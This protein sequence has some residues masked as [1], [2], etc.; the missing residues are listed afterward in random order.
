MRLKSILIFATTFGC[1]TLPV[2]AQDSGANN[3]AKRK[4]ATVAKP[5][6]EKER[7]KQQEKLR[8]ELETPYKKWLNE[9]VVYIITDEE[10][11]AFKTLQTDEEREQFI[12]QFWLRRDPTSGHRRKRVPRRALPPHRLR[13]RSL[14]VGHSGLEDGPRHD[15]YQVRCRRTRA[16]SIPR[17]H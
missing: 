11:K 15:L 2:A 13:Q 3:G 10:K 9:D 8:K 1:L 4:D 7:K 17:R 16:I 14:R 12:E 6:T 5:M